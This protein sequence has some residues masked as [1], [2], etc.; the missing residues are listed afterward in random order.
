[1]KETLTL[2]FEKSTKGTH[3]YV[4]GED[5]E[6]PL[7]TSTFYLKKDFLEKH[8]PGDPPKKISLTIEA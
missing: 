4:A 6:K 5:S 8:F 1:M 7:P 3:R 2:D